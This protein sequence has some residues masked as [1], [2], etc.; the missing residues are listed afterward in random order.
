MVHLS[1]CAVSF[2]NT[3]P[4]GICRNDGCRLKRNGNRVFTI[5]PSS[6]YS[7]FTHLVCVKYIYLETFAYHKFFVV[8]SYDLICFH[9]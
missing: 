8:I 1:M 5:C 3:A 2:E 9:T 4:T 6:Y 7:D